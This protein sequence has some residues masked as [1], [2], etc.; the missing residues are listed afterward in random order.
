[1]SKKVKRISDFLSHTVVVGILLFIAIYYPSIPDR[2]P[3]HYDMY[4]QCDAMGDKSNL[5]IVLG[6]MVGGY[7]LLGLISRYPHRF[8][9]PFEIKEANKLR[10]YSVAAAMVK[11]LRVVFMLTFACITIFTA[12]SVRFLTSAFTLTIL[13]SITLIL[14]IG[15]IC[16][17]KANKGH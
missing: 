7:I 15:S 4:G 2:I 10:V 16:M 3:I 9:Y 17:S 1:M 12:L 5:F 14:I 13:I 6:I 11:A 8:N